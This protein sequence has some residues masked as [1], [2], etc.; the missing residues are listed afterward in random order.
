MTLV[1][2]EPLEESRPVSVDM[3]SPEKKKPA[4]TAGLRERKGAVQCAMDDD[5]FSGHH[6]DVAKAEREAKAM[7]VER[8]LV[9]PCPVCGHRLFDEG[10]ERVDGVLYWKYKCVI[11]YRVLLITP[12]PVDED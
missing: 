9:D 1:F 3:E 4:A 2:R 5:E 8:W 10:D 12:E 11:C 6:P 7:V